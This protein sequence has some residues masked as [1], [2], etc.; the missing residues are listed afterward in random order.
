M[1]VRSARS[2]RAAALVAIVLVAAQLAG[3]RLARLSPAASVGTSSTPTALQHVSPQPRRLTRILVAGN[4]LA[5]ARGHVALRYTWAYRLIQ[6]LDPG[7]RIHVSYFRLESRHHW[8]YRLRSDHIDLVNVGV[9]G[10]D[11]RDLLRT[12]PEALDGFRPDLALVVTGTN[13]IAHKTF[14]ARLKSE[15]DEVDAELTD[16]GATTYYA[17]VPRARWRHWPGGERMSSA[18][19]E[20]NR[21]L[22]GWK[23]RRCVD[24]AAILPGR[25]RVDDAHYGKEGNRRIAYA[26]AAALRTELKL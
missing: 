24:I 18:A 7:S 11:T 14:P 23:G 8:V 13:D 6:I 1:T 26:F 17:T 12:P 9:G 5:E 19:A 20:H 21:W 16:A 15:L 2:V 10:D 3:C 25:L 22:R 4:S